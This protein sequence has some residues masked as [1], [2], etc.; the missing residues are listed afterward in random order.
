MKQFNFVGKII[1]TTEEIQFGRTYQIEV[2]S[3]KFEGA[4]DD[5]MK[6]FT[7]CTPEVQVVGSVDFSFDI[8]DGEEYDDIPDENIIVV[9]QDDI[10]NGYVVIREIPL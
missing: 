2:L 10:D 3:D 6:V 1:N 5:D 4:I 8:E 7:E 9:N